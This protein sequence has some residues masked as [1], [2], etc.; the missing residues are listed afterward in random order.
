MHTPVLDHVIIT[1][2]S[3]YSFQ[4]SGLLER[5]E[6]SN[7]YVLPFE[8]EKQFHEEMEEEV[9]RIKEESKK[10]IQ[11]SLKIGEEVGLKKG[12]EKIEKIARQMLKDGTPID[13]IV[14]W[15]GLTDKQIQ[16]L[17]QG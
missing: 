1:E 10:K 17:Q 5:L 6:A 3:Y 13:H 11:E 14:K 7:K 12:E 16:K 4:T 15:T 9:K 8:L 2:K